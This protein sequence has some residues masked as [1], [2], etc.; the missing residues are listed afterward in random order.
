MLIERWTSFGSGPKDEITARGCDLVYDAH[1]AS[2]I[3]VHELTGDIETFGERYEIGFDFLPNGDLEQ[4]RSGVKAKKQS[5]Y[6]ADGYKKF[7]ELNSRS[8]RQTTLQQCDI[9]EHKQA[10]N[11]W[12]DFVGNNWSVSRKLF[13]LS[14][15]PM[16]QEVL[17]LNDSDAWPNW[18]LK[19]W[20]LDD[21]TIP[22]LHCQFGSYLTG[23]DAMVH[24]LTVLSDHSFIATMLTDNWPLTLPN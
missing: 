6:S 12:G 10:F 15:P 7:T 1:A 3:N 22:V 19:P 16:L 18:K 9:P 8:V 21:G 24:F 14:L 5:R 13:D 17:A 20:K 2:Q 23:T 11:V 4:R